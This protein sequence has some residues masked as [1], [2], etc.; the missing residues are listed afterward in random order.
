M[1]IFCGLL[2]SCTKNIDLLSVVFS[3]MDQANGLSLGL[4]VLLNNGSLSWMYIFTERFTHILHQYLPQTHSFIDDMNSS[5]FTR[6]SS[7]WHRFMHDQK[8]QSVEIA[9]AL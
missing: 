4:N 5:Q 7:S 1:Y 3:T 2:Y 8:S 6:Q 9:H